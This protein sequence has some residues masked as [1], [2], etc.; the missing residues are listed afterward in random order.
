MGG[1]DSPLGRERGN[2]SRIEGCLEDTSPLC[3]ALAAGWVLLRET[4]QGGTHPGPTGH[5]SEEGS[6]FSIPS[7]EGKRKRVPHRGLF[8][9]HVSSLCRASGG[10]GCPP[11]PPPTCDAKR[12]PP[13]PFDKLRTTP[14]GR[15][16]E[17]IPSLEGCRVAVGWV[18]LRE[19]YQKETHPGLRPPL[20]GGE[21]NTSPPRRGAALAAGWV[22][23]GPASRMGGGG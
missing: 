10:V 1:G 22:A 20:Q 9:G 5:P 4:Y 8:G 17:H 15:G 16:A 12:N 6:L 3:A 2:V 13:R 11:P 21:Q 7:W 23:P 14:P 18:L 19:T